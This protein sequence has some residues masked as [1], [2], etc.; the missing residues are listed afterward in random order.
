MNMG[1]ASTLV[2]RKL[3]APH[4]RAMFY[5]SESTRYDAMIHANLPAFVLAGEAQGELRGLKDFDR[6]ARS[7]SR[8]D[9]KARTE[10]LPGTELYLP[11]EQKQVPSTRQID[12]PATYGLKITD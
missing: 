11:P 6:A 3:I 12:V 9:Q 8:P 1:D 2:K 4:P 10:A 7:A 5:F